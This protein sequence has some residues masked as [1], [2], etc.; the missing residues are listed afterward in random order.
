MSKVQTS[1]QQDL[2]PEIKRAVAEIEELAPTAAD[3]IPTLRYLK[4]CVDEIDRV[5]LLEDECWSD[6]VRSAYQICPEQLSSLIS[7][8]TTNKRP[9]L[10]EASDGRRPSAQGNERLKRPSRR[11]ASKN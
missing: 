4:F 7:V 8:V 11:A 9:G 5:R 1:D 6:D 10:I 3:H 2:L